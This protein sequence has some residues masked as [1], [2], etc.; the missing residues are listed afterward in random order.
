MRVSRE[1]LERIARLAR[2]RLEPAEAEEMSAYLGAVLERLEPLG[3]VDVSGVESM[4]ERVDGT[5]PL[6]DDG[7]AP[8]PLRRQPADIAPAWEEPFFV[9]PRI[10]MP[11][12]KAADD[13]GER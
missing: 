6:R 2:L 3:R 11:K 4:G 10:G 8:D 9:V 7:G 1:E 12:E 13:G 5:A